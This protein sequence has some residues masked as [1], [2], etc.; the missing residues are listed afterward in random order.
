M[1]IDAEQRKFQVLIH[2]RYNGRSV[3]LRHMNCGPENTVK[4]LT[5]V[6]ETWG[7]EIFLFWVNISSPMIQDKWLC[8][9]W[10]EEQIRRIPLHCTWSSITTPRLVEAR[11]LETDCEK[12]LLLDIGYCS[13]MTFPTGDDFMCSLRV[14]FRVLIDNSALCTT[15]SIVS[16]GKSIVSLCH[17]PFTRCE[18]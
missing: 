1:K 6:T 18:K 11:W 16:W 12:W 10:N 5:K 13:K 17:L 15:I 2:G 3:Q 4:C 7:A 8:L 14:L 9:A